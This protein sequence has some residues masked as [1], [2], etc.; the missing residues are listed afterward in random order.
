MR[1]AA[2]GATWFENFASTVGT[3]L[4]NSLATSITGTVASPGSTITSP[5]VAAQAAIQ[6]ASPAGSST[7]ST[8]WPI[9]AV[10]G[11]G[12]AALVGIV[13]LKKRKRP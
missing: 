3:G 8:I 6:K 1:G 10:G 11:V 12:V 2:L 5:A 4:V 9:V 7:M 13:L